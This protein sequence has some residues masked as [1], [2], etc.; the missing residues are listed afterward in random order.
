MISKGVISTLMRGYLLFQPDNDFDRAANDVVHAQVPLAAQ[1]FRLAVGLRDQGASFL[2]CLGDDFSVLRLT[3]A[4][5]GLTRVTLEVCRSRLGCLHRRLGSLA[6]GGDPA[7]NLCFG[8][9][10]LIQG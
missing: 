2:L 7:S 4:L 8:L 6:G 10:N 9:P 3:F 5:T 1:D